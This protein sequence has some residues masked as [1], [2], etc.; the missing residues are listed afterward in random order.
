V[1]ARSFHGWCND[2]LRLYH[3]RRP[4]G[5][6]NEFIEKLVQTVIQGV[7]SGQVP[8]AQATAA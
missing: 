2:Q 7:D 5:Q 8:R 4:E 6:G 1:S 3:L